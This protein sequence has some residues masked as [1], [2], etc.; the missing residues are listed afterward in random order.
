MLT[1]DIR[2][3]R[4]ADTL[5]KRSKVRQS[6][7]APQGLLVDCFIID[8]TSTCCEH[9]WHHYVYTMQVV[10]MQQASRCSVCKC[11]YS[12]VPHPHVGRRMLASHTPALK[13][14]RQRRKGFR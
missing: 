2:L 5:P 12:Q 6:L 8:P 1:L 7:L 9:P 10:P 11:T 14:C 3:P 13:S 4:R